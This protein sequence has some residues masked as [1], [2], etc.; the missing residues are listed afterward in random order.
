MG[1]SSID[2]NSGSSGYVNIP[3]W[4]TTWW[5]KRGKDIDGDVADDYL[6]SFIYISHDILV[7][8]IGSPHTD[9][10]GTIQGIVTSTSGLSHNLCG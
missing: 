4:N 10:N 1:G 9:G 6:G 3:E 8:A 5:L 2:G 7:V